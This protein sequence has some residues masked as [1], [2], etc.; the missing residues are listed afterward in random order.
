MFDRSFWSHGAKKKLK[1]PSSRLTITTTTTTTTKKANW[2]SHWKERKKLRSVASNYSAVVDFQ[3]LV[4]SLG[5]FS[6]F[7]PFLFF[8]QYQDW[9]LEQVRNGLL[10]LLFCDLFVVTVE[11]PRSKII[12]FFSP[13][14]FLSFFRQR[15]S[16]QIVYF[17][18]WQLSSARALPEYKRTNKRTNGQTNKRTNIKTNEQTD[19]RTKEGKNERSVLSTEVNYA[20]SWRYAG[21]SRRRRLDCCH[22]WERERVRSL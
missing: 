2:R 18:G 9:K 15:E 4:F 12:I 5:L 16:F 3:F 1:P 19:K 7:R 8:C 22:R 10:M 6:F 21:T 20:T 13:S 17:D 11:C 14:F